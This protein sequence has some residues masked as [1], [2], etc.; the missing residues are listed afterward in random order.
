MTTY[1]KTKTSERVLLTE[2]TKQYLLEID[3]SLTNIEAAKNDPNIPIYLVGII[4]RGDAVNKNRRIYPFEYLKKECERYLAEEIRNQQSF[5]ELDHPE[6][7]ATPSLKN[8]SHT[9]EDIWFKGTEVWGKVKLLNAYAPANDPSLKAR[10]I[11]LNNKVLGISSRAL[12]SLR[13]ESGCDVVESDLEI[14]CWDLVSNASTHGANLAVVSEGK[15]A[16]KQLITESQC[17]TLKKG[18]KESILSQLSEAERTYL[19]IL[20]VEKF[21][22]LYKTNLHK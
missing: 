3:Q 11:I 10:S 9:L 17:K 16:R 18:V 20:G 22:H 5:G 15:N 13:E 6:D 4:Q 1:T 8:T 14:I 21:L 12:G 2:S 19:N 7:S